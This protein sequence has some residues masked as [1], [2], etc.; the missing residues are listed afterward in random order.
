[1]S[2][3]ANARERIASQGLLLPLGAIVLMLVAFVCLSEITGRPITTANGYDVFQQVGTY[4]LVALAIALT[5]VAG[6]FD[7]S[8]PAMFGLGG[9]LAVLTGESD[10]YVGVAVAVAAA[11]VFGALQGGIVAR[12]RI[13]S[14]PVT[15]GGYLILSGLTYILTNSKSIPYDNF[16]AVQDLDTP[17]GMVLSVHSLIVLLVFAAIG[18]VA[19]FTKIG[20]SLRAIGGD[21]RAAR[22]SGVPVS[23]YL[24]AT[25]AFS[26]ALAALA[27]ALQ[28]YAL[29]GT[30]PNFALSPLIFAVTASV[31]GGVRLE[32]GRGTVLGVAAG[33][34][35]LSIL[36]EGLVVLNA[37]DSLSQM[38]TGALLVVVALISAPGLRLRRT[39]RARAGTAAAEAA[40]GADK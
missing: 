29:A 11:L 23:K 7:L 17:V 20:S 34:A 36:E 15:L 16:T 14:V 10:P 4:G 31:L 35:A 1:M 24:V 37:S 12:L 40:L 39:A 26:S 28:G 18:V 33:V 13:S 3:F 22:A 2:S 27:G 38:V 32:G 21:R 6:E 19:H 5:M 9:T 30:S 8:V 25:L